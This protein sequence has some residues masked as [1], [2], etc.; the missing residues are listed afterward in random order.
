MVVEA[1]VV[2]EVLVGGEEGLDGEGRGDGRDVLQ[3][4]HV[5]H[6]LVQTDLRRNN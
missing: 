4:D 5:A 3:L 1:G 2:G 6:T